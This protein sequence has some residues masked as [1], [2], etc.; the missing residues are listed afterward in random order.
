M[1]AAARGDESSCSYDLSDRNIGLE[2]HLNTSY[3]LSIEEDKNS[4][5]FKWQS[6][7]S[8]LKSLVNDELSLSG[9]WSSVSKSSSS[10]S[11]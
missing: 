11:R 1:A 3:P 8:E 5:K 7:F 6:G 9:Q 2:A 10:C 4:R